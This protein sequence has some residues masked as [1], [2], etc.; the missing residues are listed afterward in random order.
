MNT[1]I[2]L[3]TTS[4]GIMRKWFLIAAVFS[5]FL[6]SGDLF[7]GRCG[8]VN[9]HCHSVP[10]KRNVF[11]Q[12]EILIQ[13][14]PVAY[15]VLVPAYQYQYSPPPYASIVNPPVMNP[16]SVP[17]V[18]QQGMPYGMP[19]NPYNIQQ[20]NDDT[21]R[22]LAQLLLKEMEKVAQ[23]QEIEEGPPAVT[24]PWA[25][26]NPQH[27]APPNNPFNIPQPTPQQMDPQL[28]L[29]AVN[30]F[31]RNCSACHTGVGSKGDEIIFM[32]P[33]ILNS[34]ASWGQV[35]RK[36]AS[37]QM[38]PRD[39]QFRPTSAEFDAMIKFA[40]FMLNRK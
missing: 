15:P 8:F 10:I 22:R 11:V 31:A 2:P 27:T 12:K 37:G 33:G 35:K 29:K 14:V 5:L 36:I 6:I 26:S 39:S 1:I 34:N 4:R 13:E 30:A 28:Q 16:Y 7:A 23:E 25:S 24:G 32:Q 9:S 3:D 20:Q 21:L 17:T 40:D 38:P 19:H 18:Q